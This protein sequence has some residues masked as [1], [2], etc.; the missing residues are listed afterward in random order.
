MTGSRLAWAVLAASGLGAAA[1]GYAF[2][3]S[4]PV[5]EAWLVAFVGLAGVASGALGLLMLGHL[6]GGYW[7]DPVRSELEAA[8]LTLPLVA[9]VGVPLAFA[10]DGLYPWAAPGFSGEDLPAPRAAWLETGFVLARAAV[11]LALWCGLAFLLAR[12]GEHRGL[13]AAGLAV[14]APTATLAA[15]DW[16]MSRDPTWWSSLFGFA[17]ASTQ[18]LPALAGAILLDATRSN[19]PEARQLHSLERALIT[20]ALLVLWTWFIQFLI[21]WMANLPEEAGWYLIR[22]E[23]FGWLPPL[24][25]SALVLGVVLLIPPRVGGV[26][27]VSA[28][29]LLLAQH[30]G[31]MVWLI[32]PSPEGA[33][34]SAADPIVLGGLGLLWVAWAFASLR[35][36]RRAVE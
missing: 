23:A 14:L 25:V 1:L 10:L 6:I 20:L 17:F 24:V 11:Y 32:R 18:L 33:E 3:A 28:C 13:S 26:L 5:M 35:A 27:L 31:H 22:F 29:L 19:R 30:A 8:A 21:I 15:I 2:R 4:D 16:V 36:R 12:P 9:L 34:L 7:L